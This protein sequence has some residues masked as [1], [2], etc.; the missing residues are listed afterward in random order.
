MFVPEQD[1]VYNINQF[2]EGSEEREAFKEW[3][4]EVTLRNIRLD[5]GEFAETAVRA[6]RQATEEERVAIALRFG[7]GVP[8]V[9]AWYREMA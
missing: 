5:H 1:K 2:P 3:I 7:R 8:G 6:Y 9:V 4:R